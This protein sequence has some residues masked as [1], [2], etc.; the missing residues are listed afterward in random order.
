LYGKV[1]AGDR[2]EV[3]IK[4]KKLP[5]IA[6]VFLMTADIRLLLANLTVL[7]SI[8]TANAIPFLNVK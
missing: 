2:F 3:A 7:L 4:G 6:K 8:G 1:V 5:L